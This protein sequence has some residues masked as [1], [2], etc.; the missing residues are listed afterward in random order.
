[1]NRTPL[2]S[3]VIAA[4][5]RERL[6]P[7]TLRSVQEQTCRDWE[8]VI[9][10]DK[11]TDQSLSVANRWARDDNRFR[12]VASERKAGASVTRN[13]GFAEINPASTFVTFMDCDDVWLP[14]A[15]STL[16]NAAEA[17]PAMAG[18][19]GLADFIDEEGSPM[20][21]GKFATFGRERIGLGENGTL[22]EWDRSKP[23]SF[24]TLLVKN[25]VFPPGVVLTRR[26]FFE[27]TGL[28][29][30]A[31]GLVEDWDMILRL[32]RYGSF[33]FVNQVVIQYRRHQGSISLQSHDANIRKVRAF[34]YK[35]FLSPE[36]TPEQKVIARKTWR[37]LQLKAMRVKWETVRKRATAGNYLGAGAMLARIYVEIHRFLR[38]YPT[39]RGL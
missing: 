39:P 3:I 10:D 9:V 4:H 12:A 22:Q 38:G 13:R 14:D 7:I 8:C 23:T 34:Q 37:Q 29:D 20:L 11:S 5:N 26:V 30:P 31:M 35:S 16:L 18:A 27:K 24:N 21:P 2:I 28:F 17:S 36:N 32:S 25:T 6:L 19:H 1:M 15:L 33:A